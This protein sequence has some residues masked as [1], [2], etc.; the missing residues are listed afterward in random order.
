VKTDF[1]LIEQLVDQ[2]VIMP[3]DGD[4]DNNFDGTT[5]LQM[6][7]IQGFLPLGLGYKFRNFLC[8]GSC[9]WVW[10]TSFVT[11]LLWFLHLVYR[12]QLCRYL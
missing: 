12:Y 7:Q 10:V 9:L 4:V 3:E 1:M 2:V 11:F 8:L 5:D 6:N